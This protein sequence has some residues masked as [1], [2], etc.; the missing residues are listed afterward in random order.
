M[1]DQKISILLALSL[2]SG[3]IALPASPSSISSEDTFSF[4]RTSAHTMLAVLPVL[5]PLSTSVSALE[6]QAAHIRPSSTNYIDA[7]LPLET[8][9]DQVVGIYG[10]ILYPEDQELAQK[11]KLF[12]WME[13]YAKDSSLPFPLSPEEFND[14]SLYRLE[15]F[16][17]S[18]MISKHFAMR[19]QNLLLEGQSLDISLEKARQETLIWSQEIVEKIPRLEGRSEVLIARLVQCTS[20][21]EQTLDKATKIIRE[22][23]KKALQFLLENRSELIGPP[24]TWDMRTDVFKQM[25]EKV[26]SLSPHSPYFLALQEVTP[27]ALSDLK[28]TLADRDLQWLSFNNVSGK[29]TLAPRQEEVLG[30]ATG[31]TSTVALSRDL[32][33]LKVDL[34]DLPT[35]SGSVRKILGVRVRNIHTNEIFTIFSTHTDH[36]IQNDIYVRTAAK[37]HEFATRFF[38]DTPNEQRFVIGGDLNVF[39]Q[40]DGGKYVAKL[41]ELFTGSKDF[42]ETDYYAPPPIAWSSFIGRSEG[43]FS[44]RISKEGIIEPNALDQ[45][46]VGSGIELQS[47]A[48]EALVYNESGK[49]LD[50]YK[51]RDEYIANLQKRI[52]FS[53][54]FFN[55]VRF[56]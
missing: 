56:K 9:S 24:F 15:R 54:H 39:E 38:Q 4:Q 49:L 36:K 47:A 52:T 55:I 51:E 48:R 12:D 46:I 37:I 21:A 45:V 6:E 34:G 42:R 32:E 3:P 10:N 8:N 16:P 31:F 19:V 40:L 30:E 43:P 41:R 17:F 23:S 14:I 25:I 5:E 44:P 26:I 53:D 35:E 50:Y 7:P 1:L 11:K 13:A 28:E 22:N 29:I 20:Q 2:L 33:I 27:Q 18:Q